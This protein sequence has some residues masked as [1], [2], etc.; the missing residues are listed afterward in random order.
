MVQ[1]PMLEYH[2][3]R[4]NRNT[5]AAVVAFILEN[6]ISA[7]I[8]PDDGVFRASLKALATLS[9]DPGL[10]LARLGETGFYSQARFLGI[11]LVKMAD[12]A[13][14]HA[15]TATTAFAGYNS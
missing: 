13:D 4:T 12:S 8:T 15:Q 9:A 3:R 2:F 11:D 14:L 5:L 10:E 1:I 7:V 6:N